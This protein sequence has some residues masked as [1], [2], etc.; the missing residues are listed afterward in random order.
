MFLRR[1]LNRVSLGKSEKYRSEAKLTGYI[2]I[3]IPANVPKARWSK[4]VKK[5][6]LLIPL[7]LFGF[8]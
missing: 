2:A 4:M 3:P 5:Y 8:R 1:Q 7:P 6:T